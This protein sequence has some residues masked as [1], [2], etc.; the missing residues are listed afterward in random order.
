MNLS[1]RVA[2]MLRAVVLGLCSLGASAALGQNRQEREGLLMYWGVVPAAVVS[3][4][5]ALAELHGG[6]PSGDGRLH[7]LVVALFDAKTGE[8]LD[9]AVVRAQLREIGVVEETPKY[10][11]P[12]RIND[13]MTYGA[14]F[15]TVRDGPYGLRVL[16]Q[17]PGGGQEVVFEVATSARHADERRRK[18]RP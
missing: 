17:P 2:S 7:H 18:G 13:V 5:H 10:L 9:N 15:R 12:M 14:L 11:L 8:R 3:Q 1:T 6:P 4:Q 16:V